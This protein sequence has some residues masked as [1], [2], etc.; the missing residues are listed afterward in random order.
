MQLI[1]KNGIKYYTIPHIKAIQDQMLS[2]LLELDKICKDND[3]TYF[4]DG[5]SFIGALRHKG[6]IP[7]DDDLDISM[8]KNDYLKLHSILLSLDED[9]YFI[10]DKSLDKHCCMFFGRKDNIFGL[11]NS[12]R[13]SVYPF[14][15]DIRP[16]NSIPNT[17][18]AKE[19][20]R[21][22]RELANK[23]IFNKVSNEYKN[24]VSDMFGKFSY[25]KNKFLHYYNTEYGLYKGNDAVLVHPYMN[26]STGKY[27]FYSD[28][29]PVK[30]VPFE[31]HTLPIP[32]TDKLLTEVY[33][34]YMEFP[35]IE[36]R[37]PEAFA[38]VKAK[39]DSKDTIYDLMLNYHNN[40]FFRI[41]KYINNNAY[42]ILY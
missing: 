7:W 12:R 15:I 27:Y 17:K 8:N 18:E 11:G 42:L 37:K 41:K 2:V 36:D 33:G 16:L 3:L 35:K 40:I 24:K 20:N 14:K 34:S 9:K 10:F 26:Y 21:I 29:F 30:Q 13:T 39:N 1:E 6:F 22:Y 28:I 5:G 23:I 32:S 25:D 38:V 31:D 4:L 19:E